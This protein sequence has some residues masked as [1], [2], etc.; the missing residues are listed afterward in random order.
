MLLVRVA[1]SSF[2]AKSACSDVAK[3]EATEISQDKVRKDVSL[4]G[5]TI[6]RVVVRE[7]GNEEERLP[8]LTLLK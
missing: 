1:P 5:R 2:K 8:A 4:G 6:S 3:S 7:G